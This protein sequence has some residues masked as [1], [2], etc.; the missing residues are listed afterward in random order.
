MQR[1]S[2]VLH[3]AV[4]WQTVNEL[5]CGESGIVHATTSSSEFNST[6]YTL[7]PTTTV[8]RVLVAA[9]GNFLEWYDFAVYGIFAS[10]IGNAFFPPED[11]PTT[12]LIKTYSIFA[13]AFFIRPLGGIFFGHIG[14]TLGREVALLFTIM[15]MATPTLVIGLLPTYTEIGIASPLLLALMRMLQGL[16]AGGELPGALVYAVESAGPRHRAM[17][18][19]LCQATGVGSL[20]ASLVAAILH[21][22]LGDTAVRE[23]GWRVPF[24]LGAGIAVVACF[25]RRNFKP[26]APFLEAKAAAAASTPRRVGCCAWLASL[27]LAKTMRSSWRSVLR[28]VCASP[29]GMVGF[30]GFFVFIPSWLRHTRLFDAAFALNVAV[31]LLWACVV[32][33]GGML[34]DRTPPTRCCTRCSG[35]G[36]PCLALHGIPLVSVLGALAVAVIAPFLFIALNAECQ[37]VDSAELLCVGYYPPE[38]FIPILC[39]GVIAHGCHVGPLQAWFVLSLKQTGSRYSSLGVAYNV[40][41]ALL[42]GTTP[43]INTALTATS[44]GAAGAGY[45][46]AAAA[47]ISALA[48]VKP[49]EGA[50]AFLNA[51]PMRDDMKMET[52]AMRITV[53]RRLGLPLDVA[54]QAVEAGK[55]APNGKP[56]E[57][58]G[59]AAMV[60]PRA[61]HATRQRVN[62][63]LWKKM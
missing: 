16:A 41:A 11:S 56:H 32:V 54:C 24:V 31:M 36:R 22:I 25:L 57:E 59:D 6:P 9:A 27:P 48:L 10:D 39:L 34:A 42:G 17:M 46:L 53:Q 55:K 44:V 61:K 15:L 50:G 43:L 26:T 51:I 60:N 13:G 49:G 30:Y 19:A 29:L 23:W 7:M 28:I 8:V 63:T 40:G 33:G 14:D 58:L 21:W 3:T 45:Y 38:V 35:S 18:G 4:A 37:S 47:L 52:W 5:A 12:A 20:L 62:G 1:L 2:V